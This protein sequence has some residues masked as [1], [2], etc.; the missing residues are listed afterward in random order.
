MLSVQN[1]N[2]SQNYVRKSS[3]PEVNLKNIKD[4]DSRTRRA[5]DPCTNAHVKK[6]FKKHCT[7]V[8]KASDQNKLRA[9]STQGR[10]QTSDRTSDGKAFFDESISVKCIRN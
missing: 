4:V 5:N 2:I 7:R 10:N 3:W 9:P 6:R 1:L 8:Q